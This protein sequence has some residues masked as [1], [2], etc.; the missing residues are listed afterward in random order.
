MVVRH[1]G[2]WIHERK[3]SEFCRVYCY[4]LNSSDHKHTCSW[5]FGSLK[6]ICE[7]LGQR[8]SWWADIES[9]RLC[10]WVTLF[11]SLVRSYSCL[12]S[13]YLCPLPS[14]KPRF[15][16]R[17][18]M[19]RRRIRLEISKTIGIGIKCH[20]TQLKRYWNHRKLWFLKAILVK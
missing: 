20:V 19:I 3:F 5:S 16:N 14:Q 15:L 17:G 4:V 7:G 1:I 6:V 18:D 8:F 9:K 13:R 12:E 10:W 11:W 2:Y